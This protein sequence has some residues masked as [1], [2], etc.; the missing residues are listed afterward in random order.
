MSKKKKKNIRAEPKNKRNSE[1]GFYLCSSDAFETLTCSG[2]TS[3][4][5]NPEIIS[6]VDTIARLIGSMTI[7]LMENKE[8]GDVRVKNELSRKI[9]IDPNRN[10]TRMNF[11]VWIIRTMMVE[12]DGN[13]VVYPETRRGILKNLQ[14]IPP[15]M[16]AFI[17]D[18]LWNYKVSI[19]GDLYD[20]DDILH[21]VLNPGSYYP[22]KGEGYRIALSDVAQ[23][24]KQGTETQKGFMESKW[25]PS[26]IVK[27]DALT[28]EFAG[29]EG[30]RKLL[31]EYVNTGRAGE[32]WLIPAEQFSIEQVKPLTLS[33]LALSE[34]IQLDKKTVAGIL[35]IPAFVLGV[36]EFKRDEW[37]N[38]IS[39]R[40][41]PLAKNIEQELT[42]KLLLNPDWF[43]RFNSRSLYNYD[44]RDLA[45][46][47]DS[48]YERGIMTGNEARDWIGM[49]PRE[50]LD[51]LRILENYIPLSK[52]GDQSKL[53]G[54]E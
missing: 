11:V 5:H 26:L 29:K 28:E 4:A 18:G 44:I 41:M 40:I 37:N 1:N 8:N 7:H 12:G 52:V 49:S 17:P 38:F 16:A 20:S 25:K 24:L 23:T 45:E 36:G 32:P 2:Y 30:R 9:D 22:W 6:A 3:L 10:M 53:N 21:F 51:E 35:G 34:M 19:N 54:G 14:P 47:A 31:D 50:G 15:A 48:Q 27:V 39:S 43:F 33:D 42:R 46:V 13:A